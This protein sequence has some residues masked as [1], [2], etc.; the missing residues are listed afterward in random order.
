MY[1]WSHHAFPP[2]TLEALELVSNSHMATNLQCAAAQVALYLV[3]VVE[4]LHHISL[5]L[6][7]FTAVM[8]ERD[9][10]REMVLVMGFSHKNFPMC[11]CKTLMLGSRL[12]N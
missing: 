12:S 3:V 6:A 9:E 5:D 4:C 1:E 8:D 10:L 7:E 11:A 2:A